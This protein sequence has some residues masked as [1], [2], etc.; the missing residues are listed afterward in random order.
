MRT[1]EN[2]PEIK[3]ILHSG[4]SYDIKEHLALF[5]DKNLYVIKNNPTQKIKAY[6]GVNCI[7]LQNFTKNFNYVLCQDLSDSKFPG[8]RLFDMESLVKNI[9]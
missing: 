7:G 6:S 1:Y 5:D 2:F 9:D 4:T 3:G 8:L